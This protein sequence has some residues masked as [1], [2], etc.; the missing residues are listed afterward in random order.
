MNAS[1]PEQ[2]TGELHN[3]MVGVVALTPSK[4]FVL[5]Q[6]DLF[7]EVDQQNLPGTTSEYPNWSIKMKYTLEDLNS[8]P[9]AKA[10]A[11]MFRKW[12]QKS[13]RGSNLAIP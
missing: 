7:K 2:M 11:A 13:G 1:L 6:E 10:Y 12:I 8:S 3:A 9:E 4:L 5:N